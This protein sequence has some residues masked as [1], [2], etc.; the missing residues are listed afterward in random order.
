[1]PLV[2]TRLPCPKELRKK[3]KSLLYWNLF[4]KEIVILKVGCH[5]YESQRVQLLA[6]QNWIPALALQIIRSKYF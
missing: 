1:M 5:H 2:K 4:F 6:L 3:P